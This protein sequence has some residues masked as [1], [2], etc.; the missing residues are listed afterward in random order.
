V[1]LSAFFRILAGIVI[2]LHAEIRPM[3]G[4]AMTS[5][6]TKKAAAAGL[7]LVAAVGLMAC[8]SAEPTDDPDVDRMGKFILMNKGSE[9]ETLIGYRYAQQ[10]LGAPWLLLEAA[11]TSPPNQTATIK[12]E[13]VSVTTPEGKTIQLA[14]QK[15]VN[16][17]WGV[18]MPIVNAADVVR[19]PMNYWQPRRKTLLMR[20]YVAPGSGISYDEFSVNNFRVCEGRFL[21]EIPGGVQAGRYVLTIGLE[22]SEVILP[23][24][25]EN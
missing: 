9:A 7:V 22:E 1:K 17:A 15:D 20:F 13:N 25:F 12:R 23:I 10:N 2:A 21:F 18:V 5:F 11:M 16:E 8:S 3:K 6:D 24:T 14:T 19:D 4:D